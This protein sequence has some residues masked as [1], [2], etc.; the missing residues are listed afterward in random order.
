[1]K[2]RQGNLRRIIDIGMT[3]LLILQMAY[4]VMGEAA[5]EWL[6]MGMTALVIVH[7]ILNQR[8]YGAMF[9][10]R[11]NA[12]RTVSTCVNVLLLLSFA[13]TAFCG[14][15]MSNY[16]VPFMYGVA[17]VS[18]V[19]V[20]HLSMSHW[21]FVLMGLHLG[22]HVP[23]MLAKLKMKDRTRRA[24]DVACAVVAGVGLWLFFKSGM[25]NY[26]FF[27]VPFAFLDYEKAGGLVLLENVVM[28]LFWAFAGCQVALICRKKGNPLLPVAL[29]LAAVVIG[30]IL[31]MIWPNQN[32]FGFDSGWGDAMEAPWQE[33]ES[34]PAVE[35]EQALASEPA[36]LEDGFILIEGGTFQMGSPE[37][38]NWRIDD[39]TPHEVTVAA[40]CIDP[41][42]TT[43]AEWETVMGANP[44]TFSGEK[45]P[46]ENISW[47][48]AIQ[49][50]NARSEAAGLT[51]AYAID[52]E[53]VTWDRAA[54]GYHLPTEAEW[55]YA[56]RAGTATPFNLERSLDADDA[57]FYGHY[58]Y[59]IEENYFDDSVLEARPGQY[60]GETVEV[61]GFA[62]NAWGLYDMH[63]N[64]NE[65]CWDWYGPYDTENV[66]NPTGAQAGTRHVYRG[67]GW[68]D[69]GKNMRSAYRAAGQA[70]MK[71][72][73][74]G[75]RLVRNASEALTG[76]ATVAGGIPTV[77]EG[78][79]VLIAFFS[80]GGNT[81]GIAHEIQ[82]QTG[83]DLFEIEPIPA[84]SDDYNT[85][86]ME[87]QR[88]QHDQARPEIAGR[89]DNMDEY[90][91]VL[92]GYPNWWASI[93]MPIAS[94]LEQY[95]FAGK[96]IIPFC[97][98]GGGR[99]G[100]SLTAIAK[101]APESN[102]GQGLSIHY[103]GG[104][105]LSEDVAAWLEVNHLKLEA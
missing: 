99:F 26:L 74:L 23:V 71:S 84:Y 42:E 29:I 31:N 86:L 77:S 3:V 44:S 88:D 80:W 19:R 14:M 94:F 92:L 5:H 16:A 60:R 64:V 20:T 103:S 79:K 13:L 8:W 25:P 102:M 82:R 57:N 81:R 98:H 50:A 9:K 2:K 105:T 33:T 66:D 70:D 56:C 24:F 83:Y 100:Q 49:F 40:F 76:T 101:L 65:W 36:S 38:E 62:P 78:N 46:V 37:D 73:N 52:G 18:F 45:L 6:G 43:Q 7:Q 53:S 34:E 67:G 17:R 35:P 95:D 104:S 69:F 59:E 51:P 68:N 12:Y 27:R 85:V 93:P 30:L 96:R 61:G 55:E 21:S 58:P 48:E 41:Y 75:V 32:D 63:G 10:G 22:L 15:S 47:L 11:Y 91:T 97:S 39:E 54:D 1:M 90:D 89:V 28:L 4:Q 87:A 72:Y